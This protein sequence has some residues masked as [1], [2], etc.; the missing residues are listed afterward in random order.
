MNSGT[1]GR[2]EGG[3]SISSSVDMCLEEVSI[4]S[5]SCLEGGE[6]GGEWVRLGNAGVGGMTK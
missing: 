5:D 6:M 1:F 4:S 2:S 3:V